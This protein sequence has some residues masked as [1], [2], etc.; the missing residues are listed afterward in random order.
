MKSIN[1]R[2]RYRRRR[3][4][5]QARRLVL[6]SLEHRNLL[7]ADLEITDA[8]LVDRW[9]NRI[10]APVEGELAFVRAEWRTTDLNP[11]QQYVVHYE[12][13]GIT[14]ASG[15]LTGMSGTNLSFNWYRAVAFSAPGSH[16]V[17]VLVDGQNRIAEP[18]ESN[19]EFIFSF[20]PT[21]TDLPEKMV[22]P[23]GGDPFQ[24]WSIVNYTDVNIN[25]GA[26]QDFR[27]GEFQYDGHDAFD[28]T[29]P[30]FDRMD[31]GIPVYAAASGTIVDVVDGNFDREIGGNSRPANHVAIDHGNGW[32]AY[33]YHLQ[34]ATV[35]VEIGQS[36]TAG[37]MIGLVGSSGS[38]SDAHLHFSL[39]RNGSLVEPMY[40]PGD[41]FLEA[42]AYQ[43]DLSPTVTA[44]GI[45]DRAP[46][47]DFKELPNDIRQFRTD[48]SADTWFWY[49]L[50][51]LN[52]GESLAIEWYRPD[53]TL[54]GTYNWTANGVARYVGQGWV[55]NTRAY[56]GTWTVILKHG[57]LELARETFDVIGAGG[58]PELD[59]RYGSTYI[60]DGRSTP[61][62]FG[63]TSAS[64]AA[65]TRSF[66]L[67]NRGTSNLEINAVVPPDGFEVVSSPSSIAPGS[68]SLLTVKMT[69][70]Q[71]G[72][73]WGDMILLT[74]DPDEAEFRFGIEG[75]ITGSLLPGAAA[76]Q[77][78]LPALA[79]ENRLPQAV[80]PEMTIGN[81]TGLDLANGILLAKIVS[82]KTITD[83]LV[84][85][86]QVLD[87]N[88][89]QVF[90][91][92]SPV[93]N[94]AFND[95]SGSVVFDLLSEASIGAITE[96]ARSISFV[97][98]TATPAMR[99]RIIDLQLVNATGIASNVLRRSVAYADHLP[100]VDFGDA[101][102]PYPTLLA[103]DG[104]R[105]IPI[106]ARL[107]AARDVELNGFPSVT[108]DGDD[109]AGVPDDEDGVQF[110]G[111]AEGGSL[112]AVNI[113]LTNA[114]SARVDAWIDFDRDGD[115]DDPADKILDSV[116]VSNA[117]QTLNFSLPAGVTS[118]EAYAR[119]RLSG[120]GGL[121]PTGPAADG[122]VE[123]YV[124][125]I[126]KPPTL[127]GVVVV[128][129]GDDQR[130]GIRDVTV[131]FSER[132]DIDLETGDVFRFVNDTTG[133]V[134]VDIPHIDTASGK[135]VVH[136]TFAT[137]PSVN[138]S[139]GLLDGDYVLTIDATKITYAG[140]S[141]DGNGD[142]VAGD[143]HVFGADVLDGF[144]R[145]YGDHNANGVVDLLDF[146][147]LRRT[148]GTT[149]GNADFQEGL[150]AD[151]DNS[152]GLLDFAMFRQNYGS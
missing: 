78:D 16:Q 18:N 108:A 144:Y 19:N 96:L 10:A 24:D 104:A 73:K 85:E 62:D 38:S 46:W 68:S 53:G 47:N 80:F 36:V 33:Y 45:T 129:N 66:T 151:G 114:D 116:L 49:R 23:I 95:S 133:D 14:V 17:R 147:A 25:G 88:Q 121:D 37:Q 137:G 64:S 48:G 98:E 113:L 28:I 132:V 74:N 117:V 110:G 51:H 92:G 35:A 120:A 146:A 1:M 150:D 149:N 84:L 115:W 136:F 27:G 61:I 93:A 39:Y 55:R 142:G 54:D 94:V 145:K 69:T 26:Q 86:S 131:N 20:T 124:V 7:A 60:I 12:M 101:P 105:H 123:D 44:S 122:E 81:A 41:Y 13:D 75:T 34:R 106:G 126:V 11:S 76:L 59:V 91:Q 5:D 63:T 82:G 143:D 87:I 43:G 32:I 6:E 97:D 9:N 102:A 71:V 72:E 70:T 139:G 56:A 3:T 128:N 58:S 8:F 77:Q 140:V 4:T 141:L 42:P 57:G 103:D 21:Q 67:G 135:T 107:G 65:I 112:A 2:S 152:I 29:L 83:K 15:T 99:R 118:G 111:I 22:F 90:Y 109:S 138:A 31:D 30:N 100:A 52:S 119:V 125:T 89:E 148:F 127:D 134:V 130:S 79:I 40:K 50:S